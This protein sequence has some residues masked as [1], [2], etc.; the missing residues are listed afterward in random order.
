[1]DGVNNHLLRNEKGTEYREDLLRLL[2]EFFDRW[3]HFHRVCP[4]K[5]RAEIEKA[6]ESLTSQA[7]FVRAFRD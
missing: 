6:A 4:S 3:E 2:I 5:D 1:M 7:H